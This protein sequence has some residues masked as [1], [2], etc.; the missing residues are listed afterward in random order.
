MET[1]SLGRSRVNSCS[2]KVGARPPRDGGMEVQSTQPRGPSL[3]HSRMIKRDGRRS[4]SLQSSDENN[5]RK[6]C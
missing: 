3:R 1:P 6:M 2:A 4:K 5:W